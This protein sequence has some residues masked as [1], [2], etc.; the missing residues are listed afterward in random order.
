MEYKVI[1]HS[2][3]VHQ[4]KYNTTVRNHNLRFCLLSDIHFD[5]P[6]CKR[7]ILKDH[8][9]QAKDN[10]IPIFINGDFFCIM[11]G[12]GDKR[13]N[14]SDIRPQHNSK[15]YF[16]D[17]IQEAVEWFSPYA[18]QLTLIGRGN[19]DEVSIK[20]H[21]FDILKN[22]QIRFNH[23]NPNQVNPLQIGG[24]GGYL[25]ITIRGK[26]YRIR[27]HHGNGGGGA[28][29]KGLIQFNRFQAFIGGADM[30]VF[31]HVH[32]DYETTVIEENY[33]PSNHKIEYKEVKLVRLSTYK[34][35][36]NYGKSGWHA[37]RGAQPKPI[38]GRWLD[39]HYNR[40]DEGETIKATT[41]KIIDNFNHFEYSNFG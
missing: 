1:K 21:E 15:T 10:D 34:E 17:V 7:E 6:K 13:A 9:E 3:N 28:V 33:N 4:L 25:L 31:G 16:D 39:L 11:Q 30:I 32:E 40:K 38:G 14:K 24:Y 26:T 12:K 18:E 41:T 37:E 22:F 29:T 19:H 8:L 36:F 5:N 23:A 20:Y 2:D 27:Y 35:E